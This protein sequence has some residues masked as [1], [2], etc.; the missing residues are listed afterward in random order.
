MPARA[1][2]RMR[3][4]ALSAA[5]A[6]VPSAQQALVLDAEE[7]ARREESPIERKPFDKGVCD[8][9]ELSKRLV[10]HVHVAPCAYLGVRSAHRA[11]RAHGHR[12]RHDRRRALAAL[13]VVD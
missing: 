5:E 6:L 4:A 10:G 11:A 7:A 9:L 1:R 8:G 3:R 2:P 13:H 12:H